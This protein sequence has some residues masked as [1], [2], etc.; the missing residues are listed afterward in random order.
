MPRTKKVAQVEPS[1]SDFGVTSRRTS[2]GKRKRRV[3]SDRSD[4]SEC[5]SSNDEENGT[6]SCT[7]K[8]RFYEKKIVGKKEINLIFLS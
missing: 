2:L 8:G 7:R 6:S 4:G 3:L 5:A 1:T